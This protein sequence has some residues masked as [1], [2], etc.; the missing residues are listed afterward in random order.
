MKHP[1]IVVEFFS[2]MGS[3]GVP[4]E[5]APDAAAW[6]GGAALN[7]ELLPSPKVMYTEASI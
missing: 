4:I 1:E 6:G 7:A 3:R 2:H 5:R